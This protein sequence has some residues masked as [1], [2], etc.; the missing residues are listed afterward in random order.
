MTNLSMRSSLQLKPA[1]LDL[2]AGPVAALIT[3][4]NPNAPAM[5]AIVLRRLIEIKVGNRGGKAR[6][7]RRS[8]VAEL[9]ASDPK[10][11][12]GHVANVDKT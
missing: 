4:K 9:S 3:V 2:S 10:R 7:R 11:T 8:D 6:R 12:S 5:K 1:R